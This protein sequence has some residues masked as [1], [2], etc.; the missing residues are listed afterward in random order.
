MLQ[1]SVAEEMVAGARLKKSKLKTFPL[2]TK[3][4]SD[5][6]V[7]TV[8]R[9][10]LSIVPKPNPKKHM[11]NMLAL[12]A[13]VALSSVTANAAYIF[14]AG[15]GGAF[16]PSTPS[17]NG[18]VF[19]TYA[20]SVLDKYALYDF[21]GDG[22]TASQAKT[23]GLYALSGTTY[24]LMN[25][26]VHNT[27]AAAATTAN[28]LITGEEFL[29]ANFGG[30]ITLPVG[31]YFIA[32]SE[33][34]P[35]TQPKFGGAVIADA[36]ITDPVALADGLTSYSFMTLPATASLPAAF[37]SSSLV[38]NLGNVGVIPSLVKIPE[39]GSSVMALALGAMVVRFRS[40]RA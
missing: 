12:A 28:G 7:A 5:S 20:P 24:T 34:K 38:G 1:L 17:V 35:S 26:E 15:N 33:I 29:V 10:I 3:P 9:K 32:F 40:R 14:S 21:L 27:V 19:S 30:S 4:E 16:Q 8:Y 37:G 22:W 2:L 18:T 13:A 39:A 31:T 36:P 6:T 11:K 25:S 23:V